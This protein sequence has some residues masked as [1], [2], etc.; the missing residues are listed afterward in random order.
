[1]V[2]R[3][4]ASS[5]HALPPILT[6]IVAQQIAPS[7]LCRAAGASSVRHAFVRASPRPAE[8]S[9]SHVARAPA[10][11]QGL[12]NLRGEIVTAIDLRRRLSLNEREEE[13]LPMN[14]VLHSQRLLLILDTEQPHCGIGVKI[15]DALTTNETSFFRDV[16]PFDALERS[17]PPRARRGPRERARAPD[18][19]RRVLAGSPRLRRRVH[20]QRPDLLRSRDKARHRAADPPADPVRRLP[21]AGHGRDDDQHRRRVER[22]QIGRAAVF[23]GSESC[24]ATLARRGRTG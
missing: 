22:V 1:M 8:A 15:V 6:E 17:H 4:I 16:H 5:P 10:V 20:P 9:R 21:L 14:V 18:L 7:V 12:I 2:L 19:V 3:E 13:V 23:R 11:I 24:P